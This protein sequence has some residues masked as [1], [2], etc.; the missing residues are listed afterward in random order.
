MRDNVSRKSRG[1]TISG[2][3]NLPD[4]L[5]KNDDRRGSKNGYDLIDDEDED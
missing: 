5:K 2:F 1:N 4:N 3:L